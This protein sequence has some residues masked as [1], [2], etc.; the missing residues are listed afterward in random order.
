VLSELRLGAIISLEGAAGGERRFLMAER[1][2][3]Y[4]N[5]LYSSR[6]EGAA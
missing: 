6:R 2:L 5:R 1:M 3:E 4:V